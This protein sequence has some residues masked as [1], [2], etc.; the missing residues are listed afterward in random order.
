MIDELHEVPD[1]LWV[2]NDE[3]QLHIKLPSNQLDAENWIN[4][5]HLLL[6]RLIKKTKYRINR[7]IWIAI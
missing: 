3:V 4:K 7:D 2:L 5:N 6:N 1:I